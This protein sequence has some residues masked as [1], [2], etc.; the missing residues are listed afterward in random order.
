MLSVPRALPLRIDR[1]RVK[2]TVELDQHSL[3]E[4]GPEH[5]G[6]EVIGKGLRWRMAACGN[7]I[8]PSNL[9]GHQEKLC[10]LHIALYRLH[11]V[12]RACVGSSRTAVDLHESLQLKHATRLIPYSKIVQSCVG[13]AP[14]PCGHAR[15]FGEQTF[16]TRELRAYKYS[17]QWVKN[18]RVSA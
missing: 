14:I 17:T 13:P 10:E 7:W 18:K 4:R 3:T 5:R 12:C 2:Y 8:L 11:N 6:K 1:S 15:T 16:G 9:L